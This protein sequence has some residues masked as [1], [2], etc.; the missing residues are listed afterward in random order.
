MKSN[1]KAYLSSV[2]AEKPPRKAVRV[3]GI[4]LCILGV[5]GI[6]YGFP[7]GFLAIFSGG[8]TWGIVDGFEVNL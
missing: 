8:Y 6:A 1:H 5:I 2:F 7:Q 4:I 3:F